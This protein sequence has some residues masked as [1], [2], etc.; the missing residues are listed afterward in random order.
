M[1]RHCRSFVVAFVAVALSAASAAGQSAIREIPFDSVPNFLKLPAGLYLGE[2][3]GVATNS[4]GNVF[5][6]HRSG[7]GP[8]LFEFGPDGKFIREIGQGL[9]GFVNAEKVRVDRE[10]NIWVVDRANIII[11]FNPE[12]QIVMT[13]G[14]RPEPGQEIRVVNE[15]AGAQTDSFV[16]PADIAWD[17]AGNIYVADGHGNSRIAKFDK[18]GRFLKS[19]GQRGTAAGQF[20]QPHGIAVDAQARVYVA[21]RGNR[22]IQ[23]FD[24]DGNVRGEY[25]DIGVT[26]ICISPGPR[27]FL[28]SANQNGEIYKMQL[29]GTIIG[30]FGRAGKTLKEFG[31]LHQIDCSRSENELIVG[32]VFAWRVQKVVVRPQPTTSSR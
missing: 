23:V 29:D 10:D 22:R 2:A 1:K 28:Y 13:L 8:R 24:A 3:V 15:G 19:W 30:K 5:V 7:G 9:Y 6:Y 20:N 4:K 27:Q 31:G 14:R 16:E 11:K 12:G 21:D 26:G 32:E 18:D 17:S 25:S